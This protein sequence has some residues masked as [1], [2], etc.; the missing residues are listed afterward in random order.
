M[1]WLR[2]LRYRR[3]KLDGAKKKGKLAGSL[4]G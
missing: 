1:E 4:V 3:V 2:M